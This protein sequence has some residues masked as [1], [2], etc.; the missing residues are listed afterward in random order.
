MVC[1][2]RL[3]GVDDGVTLSDVGCIVSGDVVVSKIHGQVDL[4]AIDSIQL[5]G[6]SVVS[7]ISKRRFVTHTTKAV[8][9][10]SAPYRRIRWRFV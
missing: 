2:I 3:D 1:T 7:G 5:S 9:L 4:R 10:Q 8:W 6:V